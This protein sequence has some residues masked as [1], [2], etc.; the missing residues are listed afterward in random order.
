MPQPTAPLQEGYG[1]S[2][3]AMSNPELLKNDCQGAWV[4][5]SVQH[6]TRAYVMILQ[7]GGSSPAVLT[8]QSLEPALDSLSP[9]PSTPPPAH[10]L[11]LSLKIINT[12]K[13]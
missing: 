4:A 13:E 5:Q 11:S 9:T 3:T 7:F 10:T 1:D 8:A 2:V 12:L 6:L